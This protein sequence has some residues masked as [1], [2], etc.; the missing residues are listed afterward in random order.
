MPQ[1]T[2]ASWDWY[3]EDSATPVTVNKPAGFTTGELLIGF[4]TQH[5]A[6]SQAVIDAMTAPAGWQFEA[7]YNEAQT[8]GKIWTHRWQNNDPATWNFG[9]DVGA[10]ICFAMIRVQGAET[11][12]PVLTVTSTN[13]ASLG[14]SDDSPS[15]TPKGVNDLLICFLVNICSGT[16][17]V[18]TDP[19]GMTDRGQTQAATTF[20]ACAG[21][22]QT[23]TSS[24]ATGVRTWTTV[25]P[26]NQH[27]ATLSVAVKSAADLYAAPFTGV[28]PGPDGP[29]GLFTDTIY[30]GVPDVPSGNVNAPAQDADGTGTA[31]APSVTIAVNPDAPT[32]AGTA[33]AATPAVATKPGAATGAGAAQAVTATIST[34]VAVATGAGAAQ[35]PAA[36]IA[37][38]GGLASGTGAAQAP[39]TTI[40]GTSGTAT[41]SG[42]PGAP[43]TTLL[44]N[45]GAATGA[46]VAQTPG[47][48]ISGTSGTATG[49]GAPGAPNTALLVNP[50]TATGT[51]TAN[52]ATVS[53]A[54][55]TNAAAATATGAGA[56]Q[57]PNITIAPNSGSAASTGTAQTP[58]ASVAGTSGTATGSGTPGN[59][60]P[61][62]AVH[63][64]IAS[65]TGTAN[66]ATVITGSF[67]NAAAQTATGAG[68]ANG[69]SLA[70]TTTSGAATAAGAANGATVSGG[71]SAG[72]GSGTGVANGST[73]RISPSPATAA[74]TGAALNATVAIGI[75]VSAQTATG[76][77]AAFG[78]TAL[79]LPTPSTAIGVGVAYAAQIS[80]AIINVMSTNFGPC[81]WTMVQC[82]I[83]PTGSEA[84]TGNIVTAA[85]EV[86]WQKTGQR[87]GLCTSTIRP[88]RE[89]CFRS[90]PWP[91]SG[92]G[93][94]QWTGT[95]PMPFLYRGLWYNIGCNGG[96][97]NTC[98]CTVLEEASLPGP[99][100]AITQVKLNG[101][102]M[103][104]TSYRLDDNRKLVRT[105]G[106]MWP[107]C[108]D[109]SQ[110]DTAA[111]TWSV[112][113]AWGEEVPQI[114]K[115][116]LGQLALALAEECMGE[117]CRLPKNLTSL[118][119]QG[120]SITLPEDWMRR[121]T[122]VD[123]FLDYANP[124]GL[125]GGGAIYD[126]DEPMFRR[127]ST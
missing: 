21:A 66:N 97:G 102:V 61:A 64:T 38:P 75:T 69:P 10:D 81:P 88:C 52:N 45:P 60:N 42:T 36:K 86:L 19:T 104:P 106:G 32:S 72:T 18:E 68:V 109:L 46:G 57:N 105:D 54:V 113:F 73:T 26:I 123:L 115:Q 50:A 5:T 107:T 13:F 79:I 55:F 118:V 94:G 100:N 1:A 35:T 49:S 9:Y 121:M 43:T 65:G 127:V 98:S 119:R 6:T 70:I 108:Q 53:T 62:V 63:P 8:Q 25:L 120:V 85:T 33:N 48:T 30:P 12:N 116:A 56:A 77:G 91:F 23:L 82:G 87:Y 20:H 27:G 71:A 117:D 22:S 34:S 40:S 51:G 74:S 15:V 16:L 31:P 96:C 112:T 4:L 28:S 89:D 110:P 90:Q 58:A 92:T 111:N 76:T 11:E 47:T 24:A 17:F 39:G 67:T 122:F 80:G 7:L 99:V 101:V 59:P 29:T 37:P 3:N 103:A 95:W 41:G 14:T 84:I 44:V 93:W 78:T 83:F 124:H 114:G 2:I 126:P 125:D